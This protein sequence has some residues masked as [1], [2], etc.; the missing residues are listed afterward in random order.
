MNSKNLY[1]CVGENFG[2]PCRIGYCG[3]VHSLIKWLCI[4]LP[5][6]TEEFISD[7]F[8]GESNQYCLDYIYKTFGKR[9]KK[10]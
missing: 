10:L 5:D 8:K 2:F 6:K 3:D 1:I 9:L 7:Y 4:L